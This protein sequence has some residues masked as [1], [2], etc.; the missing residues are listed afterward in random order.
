MYI[1]Y[2]L[3]SYINISIYTIYTYIHIFNALGL[4]YHYIYKV[5]RPWASELMIFIRCWSP[6]PPTSLYLEGFEARGAPTYTL[7]TKY[8]YRSQSGFMGYWVSWFCVCL[9]VWVS[10]CF[11]VVVWGAI[12]HRCFRTLFHVWHA[13]SMLEALEAYSSSTLEAGS[14]PRGSDCIYICIY[15]YRCI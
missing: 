12:M 5:L 1:L 13:G 14:V 4:T 11:R 6:E 10:V 9:C 7:Y 3:I 15:V 2:I 8:G